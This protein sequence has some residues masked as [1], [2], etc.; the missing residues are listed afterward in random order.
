MAQPFLLHTGPS[1]YML[2]ISS[3]I[4]MGIFENIDVHV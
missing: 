1:K 4:N 3:T 2:N